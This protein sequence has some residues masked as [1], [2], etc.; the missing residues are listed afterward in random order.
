M[1]DSCMSQE[2]VAV[3]LCELSTEVHVALSSCVVL[4][5]SGTVENWEVVVVARKEGRRLALDGTRQT[6]GGSFARLRVPSCPSQSVMSS[7]WVAKYSW[8]IKS[9]YYG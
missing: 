3:V 1:G 6:Y 2:D 9:Q 7:E 4:S 5:S 8:T